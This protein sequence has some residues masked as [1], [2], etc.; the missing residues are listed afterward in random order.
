MGTFCMSAMI[1]LL[2]YGLSTTDKNCG[3]HL[4]TLQPPTTEIN[5]ITEHEDS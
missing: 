5:T 4:M 3:G 2:D 1:E